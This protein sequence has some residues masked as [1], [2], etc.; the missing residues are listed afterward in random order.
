M[1]PNHFQIHSYDTLLRKRNSVATILQ[2]E[3]CGL[4]EP[5]QGFESAGVKTPGGGVEIRDLAAQGRTK[6]DPRGQLA[7]GLWALK[8]D[9]ATCLGS[10]GAAVSAKMRQDGSR[11]T[12]LPQ[13][14]QSFCF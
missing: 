6:M 13:I 8:V 1:P 5:R 9:G 11:H 12:Q 3:V 2:A 7:Q 14:T 4:E 10:L